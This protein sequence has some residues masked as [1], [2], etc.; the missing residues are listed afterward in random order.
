M[1][2]LFTRHQVSN[3]SQA[4]LHVLHTGAKA[5]RSKKARTEQAQPE[6]CPLDT[7]VLKPEMSPVEGGAFI[8]AV[9]PD[10]P[11]KVRVCG[12]VST[13]YPCLIFTQKAWDM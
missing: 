6:V 10:T 7:A 2:V 5:T 12:C 9:K 4:S 11:A 1:N 13:P 8:G 3:E